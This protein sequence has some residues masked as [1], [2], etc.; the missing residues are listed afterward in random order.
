MPILKFVLDKLFTYR[1]KP[2]KYPP[3]YRITFPSLVMLPY[4]LCICKQFC[5]TCQAVVDSMPE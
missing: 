1:V 2:N 4:T 5:F 3:E